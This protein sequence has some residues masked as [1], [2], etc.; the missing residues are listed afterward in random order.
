MKTLPKTSMHLNVCGS[1]FFKLR[2]LLQDFK[3]SRKSF[4]KSV[5]KNETV[6]IKF[7]LLSKTKH[8]LT[9]EVKHIHTE[10]SLNDFIIRFCVFNDAK[11]VEVISFQGEKPFPF[12][13]KN[14]PAL[15]SSDEKHQQNTFFFDLLENLLTFAEEIIE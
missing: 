3:D 4:E 11:M 15:Q 8:T 14:K 9:Y 7:N 12:Y 10:D 6:F 1:N 13:I 2:K 5:N